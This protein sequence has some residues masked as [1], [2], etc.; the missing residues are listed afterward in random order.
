[1]SY[2]ITSSGILPED[3]C[4][5]HYGIKEQ[6]WGHRRYQN[7]DGSYTEAGRIRYG[8]GKK[9][10]LK[11][12]VDKRRTAEKL[13]KYS[14]KATKAYQKSNAKPGKTSGM[15]SFKKAEGITDKQ[16][17]KA[18]ALVSDNKKFHD[19]VNAYDLASDAYN[20]A[21]DDFLSNKEQ[22][23]KVVDAQ[24]EE[25]KKHGFYGSTE[26]ALREYYN[27]GEGSQAIL[28]RYELN[29]D[30]MRVLRTDEREK[31]KAFRDTMK[32]LYDEALGLYGDFPVNR[33][34]VLSKKQFTLSEDLADREISKTLWDKRE[35]ADKYEADEKQKSDFSKLSK[36][37]ASDKKAQKPEYID[38]V[39]TSNGDTRYFY[40]TSELKAYKDG[41]SGASDKDLDKALKAMTRTAKTGEEND[42]RESAWKRA[43]DEDK[44][45]IDFIE[46]VQNSVAMEKGDIKTLL[47]EYAYYLS[48]PEKYS[49]NREKYLKDY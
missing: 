32:D 42:R 15:K 23:A 44:W 8:I 37:Y 10:E 16:Y 18:H 1:M 21:I 11:S 6:R 40:D 48:D 33:K 4:L 43:R 36:E 2:Y 26:D 47:T 27:G 28:E 17:E 34:D 46:E 49:E 30:H 20:K 24:I 9:R 14:N 39:K 25:D 38:K 35:A 19:A 22:Y 45:D 7:Y 5:A 12:N 13:I 41:R 29:N 3:E 31:E